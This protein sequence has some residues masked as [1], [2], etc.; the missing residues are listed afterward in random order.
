MSL[1]HYERFVSSEEESEKKVHLTGHL[2]SIKSHIN[3]LAKKDY[4]S[5]A[6]L[7]CP[8][9]TMMFVPIE[10]SLTLALTTD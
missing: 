4:P 7:R 10:S 9:F 5:H 6:D 8:D 1:T 3:E 2:S